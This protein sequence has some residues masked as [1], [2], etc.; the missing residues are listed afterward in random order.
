VEVWEQHEGE[1][2]EAYV[3]FLYYRNMGPT[4]S[5][6]AAY[7]QYVESGEIETKEKG[8]IVAPKRTKTPRANGQWKEDSSSYQ[9]EFRANKWDIHMLK[10]AGKSVIS[11]FYKLLAVTTNQTLEA[12]RSGKLLPQTYGQALE[13]LQILG[14]FVQPEA[15][16]DWT[17]ESTVQPE[18]HITTP[19]NVSSIDSKRRAV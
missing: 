9:W 13:G 18:Q 14:N 19:E 3:R 15:A 12:M 1:P 17:L 10:I 7:Q 5:L 16:A 8:I 4:R 2:D 6:D 11:D